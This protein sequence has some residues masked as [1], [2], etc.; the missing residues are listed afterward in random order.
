[1]ALSGQMLTQR[2]QLVPRHFWLSYFAILLTV[3]FDDFKSVFG[4]FFY[5]FLAVDALVYRDF[6]DYAYFF[7]DG[8]PAG[9][10]LFYVFTDSFFDAGMF[11]S[12]REGGAGRRVQASGHTFRAAFPGSSRRVRRDRS[13]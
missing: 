8:K 11:K 6:E 7:E 3:Y 10:Y 4:T 1:M 9:S 5:A 13:C 12:F 2:R